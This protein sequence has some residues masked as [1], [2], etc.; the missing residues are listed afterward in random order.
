L[1]KVIKYMHLK[2]LLINSNE[3]PADD[4]A[5]PNITDYTMVFYFESFSRNNLVILVVDQDTVQGEH[6]FGQ[7]SYIVDQLRETTGECREKGVRR[8]SR[9]YAMIH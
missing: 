5:L 7:G 6:P 1:E 9:M 3:G 2:T 8:D 4:T